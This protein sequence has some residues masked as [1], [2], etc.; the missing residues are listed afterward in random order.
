MTAKKLNLNFVFKLVAVLL[1]LV[2]V[3][4]HLS[5]KLYAKY[6]SRASGSDSARVAVW[7]V[8][9]SSN[10]S[11]LVINCADASAVD[12]VM[13][14]TY[15][16]TVTNDSEVAVSYDL[17]VVFNQA[18]ADE[19][20]LTL[21]NNAIAATTTTDN[22]TFVFSNVGQLGVGSTSKDHTLTFSVTYNDIDEDYSYNFQVTADFEQID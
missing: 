17:I 22:K 19:I 16:L 8:D 13:T 3:T 12:Q 2:L 15:G 9:A 18:L 1:C 21:D 4:T 20:T 7:N 5:S 6:T 10:G 14:D 11:N